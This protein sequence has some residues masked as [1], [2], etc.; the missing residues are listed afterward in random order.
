MDTISKDQLK[1]LKKRADEA[2][3]SSIWKG[4]KTDVKNYL[5]SIKDKIQTALDEG[6]TQEEILEFLTS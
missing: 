3:I 6:Y 1:S 4:K 5:N 2:G